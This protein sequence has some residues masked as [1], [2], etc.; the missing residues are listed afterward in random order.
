MANGV[1]DPALK[2]RILLFT[3]VKRQRKTNTRGD[4]WSPSECR[5]FYPSLIH[6]LI[7]MSFEFQLW[8]APQLTLIQDRIIWL[9]GTIN[10][11]DS[12]SFVQGQSSSNQGLLLRR[13]R[14]EF[15][16]GIV[17]GSRSLPAIQ[18]SHKPPYIPLGTYATYLKYVARL[19][20]T[21]N[22]ASVNS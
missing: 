20:I 17:K 13:R 1:A 19:V 2:W 14:I 12:H 3:V 8:I 15:C 11:D 22:S 16:R 4:V 5:L 6:F 18:W 10:M 9:S 7:S 21:P